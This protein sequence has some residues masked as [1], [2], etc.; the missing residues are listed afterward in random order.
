[1][2]ATKSKS[3]RTAGELFVA[4][5]RSPDGLK[6]QQVVELINGISANFDVVGL[7]VAEHMPKTAITL[8][9]LL[10]GIKLFQE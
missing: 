5:G 9:N 6:V 1:M 7:A 3:A 2:A 4:V 10:Q 8:R